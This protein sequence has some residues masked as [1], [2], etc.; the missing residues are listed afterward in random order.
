MHFHQ[1]VWGGC[2]RPSRP[3]GTQHSWGWGWELWRLWPIWGL[4]EE[5]WCHR[6]FTVFPS[7]YFL[8]F[9]HTFK[10]FFPIFPV[11]LHF[12]KT[13]KLSLIS[14]SRGTILTKYKHS[15][16]LVFVF[17]LNFYCGRGSFFPRVEV[18][19]MKLITCICHL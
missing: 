15:F 4:L 17:S 14:L 3:P 18:T 12:L 7:S 6:C 1:G 19:S 16:P 2:I 11:P 8:L 5:K 13:T 10:D 9:P